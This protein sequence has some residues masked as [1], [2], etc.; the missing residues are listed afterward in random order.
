MY[1]DMKYHHETLAIC[2]KQRHIS[3]Q[4]FV[5]IDTSYFFVS[6]INQLFFATTKFFL[7]LLTTQSLVIHITL[8]KIEFKYSKPE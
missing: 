1:F 3:V 2:K 7:A 4:I 6:V 8:T 5:N